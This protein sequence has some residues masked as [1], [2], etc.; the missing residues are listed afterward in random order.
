MGAEYLFYMKS[1]E[2]HARAFLA[3]IIL[4]I[5]TVKD[6]TRNTGI[7]LKHTIDGRMTKQRPFTPVSGKRLHFLSSVSY[8]H[9]G[10]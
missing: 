6:V 3:L 2:N 1:I 8:L 5:G 7:H 4:P 9:I 10:W